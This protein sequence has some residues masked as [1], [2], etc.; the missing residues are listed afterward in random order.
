M[1]FRVRV[2]ETSNNLWAFSE[3]VHTFKVEA[4]GPAH[5]GDVAKLMGLGLVDDAVEPQSPDWYE[6]MK[7]FKVTK[8]VRVA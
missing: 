7:R 8:V 6:C 5:A 3:Q 2:V 4:N 1:L